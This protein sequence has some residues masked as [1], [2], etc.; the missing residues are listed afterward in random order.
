M[1]RITIVERIG[2]KH[3]RGNIE[4]GEYSYAKAAGSLKALEKAVGKRPSHYKVDLRFENNGVVVLVETKQKF[5]KSDEGQLSEY[6]DEE[7]ALHSSGKIIAMLANT[8][9]DRIKVWQGAIDDDP[10]LAS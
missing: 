7:Q 10:V 4:N 2:K 5:R 1:D 6:L 3:L 8:L 9:D